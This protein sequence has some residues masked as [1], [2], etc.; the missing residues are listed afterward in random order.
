MERIVMERG[1]NRDK[2]GR[3]KE[4][5][6]IDQIPLKLRDWSG[7]EQIRFA[8]ALARECKQVSTSK[9]RNIYGG[10]VKTRR[11][12]EEKERSGSLNEKDV[13]KI[14]SDLHLMRAKVAYF[15]GRSSGNE[16]SS[17]DLFKRCFEKMVGSVIDEEDLRTIFN[18]MES[19]VAYHKY[20]AV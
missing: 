13:H 17:L 18:V 1:K 5:D 6:L 16:K 4:S 10:V 9:M 3:D 20:Y 7:E 12:F 8:E 14:I 2:K 19:I 15:V 11:K